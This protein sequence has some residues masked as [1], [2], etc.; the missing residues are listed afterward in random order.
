MSD[1]RNNAVKI[2]AAATALWLALAVITVFLG[3]GSET[4]LIGHLLALAGALTPVALIWLAVWFASSLDAL[5]SEAEQLRAM[6]E[7]MN[8]EAPSAPAEAPRL[9]AQP[10][11]RPVAQ[12]RPTQVLRPAA[13][14]TVPAASAPAMPPPTAAPRPAPESRQG[15]LGFDAPTAPSVTDEELVAALNFPNGPQD[16]ETIMA[17][18]KTLQD[19]DLAKLIRAAQDVVT[20]LANHGIYM[21]DT[22]PRQHYPAMWRRFAAGMRGDDVE[23]LSLHVSDET[24]IVAAKMLR[25][26]EVFR[27]AAHHFLRHFDRLVTRGAAEFDDELLAALIDTRSGRAFTLLAQVTGMIGQQIAVEEPGA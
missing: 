13:A 26:D 17:L 25:W 23:A 12:S 8:R 22:P 7:G 18:R 24:L 27:D 9:S 5:R 11:P 20:L 14:A 19:R 10:A 15:S 1:L 2:G 6:L 21:D 3:G 16:R 4:G